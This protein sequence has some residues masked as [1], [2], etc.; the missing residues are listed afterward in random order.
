[1][2]IRNNFS[3]FNHEQLHKM[4]LISTNIQTLSLKTLHLSTKTPLS[5]RLQRSHLTTIRANFLT[6]NDGGVNVDPGYDGNFNIT[7]Q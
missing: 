5:S 2:L 6:S 4:P 7:V 1:M 3:F